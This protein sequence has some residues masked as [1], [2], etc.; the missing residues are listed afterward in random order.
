MLLNYTECDHFASYPPFID[1]MINSILVDIC[2]PR[3]LRYH[4]LANDIHDTE[5]VPERSV[6]TET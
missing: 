6:P 3:T 2:K 1:Y 4:H 5:R